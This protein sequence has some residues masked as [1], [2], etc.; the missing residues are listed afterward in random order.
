VF[1]GFTSLFEPFE[2]VGELRPATLEID[3]L[4]LETSHRLTGHADSCD[5]TW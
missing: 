4:E 1:V 5:D 2:P 3:E